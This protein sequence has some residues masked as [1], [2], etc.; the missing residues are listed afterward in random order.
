MRGLEWFS[1]YLA[2][3]SPQGARLGYYPGVTL[4]EAH[5]LLNEWRRN[6]PDKEYV[7]MYHPYPLEMRDTLVGQQTPT[8]R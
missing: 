3:D 1:G 8:V 7:A 6:N 5:Q 4:Y 2:I